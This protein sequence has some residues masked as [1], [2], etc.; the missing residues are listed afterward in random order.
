MK[1]KQIRLVR[2]PH[3]LPVPED[4]TMEEVAVEEPQPGQVVV[5]VTHVSLDPYMRGMMNAGPS[6]IAAAKIGEAM[7]AIGLGQV[8]VSADDR[9]RVGTYV[10]GPTGVQ[11]RAVMPVERLEVLDPDPEHLPRYLG[12]LGM[13][14]L[15]AYFGLL[16]VG[17]LRK[18][19]TVLVSGAAGAVGQVVGQIAR[20]RGNR[21]IGIAGR[22]EKCRYVVETLGFD[23]AINYATQDLRQELGRL[24]PD[25]IDVYF[26]NVGGPALEAALTFIRRR[27]RIV[28]CGGISQYNA[29]QP[30]PGPNNYLSL[31][32]RSARMEGFIVTDFQERNPEGMRELSTWVREGKL[33]TREHVVDGLESFHRAFLMLFSGDNFGKLVLKVGA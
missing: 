29:T 22:E 3:G 4:F 26:D 30:V 14:G 32:V 8:E 2:R 25:G 7:H 27:G 24:C 12:A 13:P 28:L 15:T 33:I 6:Y 17:Q 23:A 5:R 9:L 19:D 16:D 18:G 21:V 31:L 10:K 20:I 1:S 11:T